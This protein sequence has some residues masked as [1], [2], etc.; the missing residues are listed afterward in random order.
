MPIASS[1]E[2]IWFDWALVRYGDV[3]RFT[4]SSSD[5]AQS[6]LPAERFDMT[7]HELLL[8]QRSPGT[9]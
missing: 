4:R 5:F 9:G 2:M 3:Y 7:L 6:N 8:A 1:D